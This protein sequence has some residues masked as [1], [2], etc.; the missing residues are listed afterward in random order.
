MILKMLNISVIF[1]Y[2]DFFGCGEVFCMIVESILIQLFGLLSLDSLFSENSSSLSEYI[3][4]FN[5]IL[6]Y[7]DYLDPIIPVRTCLTCAGVIL[8]W[9]IT[10]CIFKFLVEVLKV[11]FK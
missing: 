1:N 10:C 8:L 2:I 7:F 11:A 3:G 9:T 6:T 5:D 4:A